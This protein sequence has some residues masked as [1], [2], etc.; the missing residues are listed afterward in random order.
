MLEYRIT[1]YN[2]AFRNPNDAY[3]REEWT[4]VS[5]IGRD[6]GGVVLTH[7][8]YS[9]VED[10]YVAVA[11]SVLRESGQTALTVRD[12]WNKPD[13][14]IEF[15]EG[16]ILPV[17]SLGEVIHMILGEKIW[18][19]LEGADGFLHFG[20]DYYMYAGVPRP[21]PES[22]ELGRALGVFVELCP[23]PYKEGGP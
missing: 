21:C 20:W 12:L 14:A 1:K 9:R 7:E 23:S 8:E 19:R 17:E 16:S 18:C 13:H 5:D 15:V 11:L 2:P 10:A 22:I 3:T 6:I 4:S